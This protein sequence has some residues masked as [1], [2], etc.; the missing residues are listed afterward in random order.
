MDVYC[1]ETERP[2]GYLTVDLHPAS[3][4][5]FGIVS[6]LLKEGNWEYAHSRNSQDTVRAIHSDTMVDCNKT[7]R[8]R[9]KS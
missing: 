2:F 8:S 6:R 4:D 7:S 3:R 9:R 5:K 1:S